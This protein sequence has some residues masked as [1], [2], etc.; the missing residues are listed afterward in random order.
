VKRAD[1][2]SIKFFSCRPLFT[3]TIEA[4]RFNFKTSCQISRFT[5]LRK[6]R[7]LHLTTLHSVII[8]DMFVALRVH[9]VFC[10][11]D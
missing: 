3:S 10:K 5:I 2:S 7:M 1:A 9:Y 11:F 8:S 4:N 6:T